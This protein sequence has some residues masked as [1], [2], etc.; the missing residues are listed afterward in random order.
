V[1]DDSPR[2]EG[3]ESSNREQK[4][5]ED[6]QMRRTLSQAVKKEFASVVKQ[7]L[8]QFQPFKSTMLPSGWFMFAH[9]PRPGFSEQIIVVISRDDRFTIELAWSSSSTVPC[10]ASLSSP[11]SYPESNIFADDIQTGECR[12]RIA[13][14]WLPRG[15]WWWELIPS[16]TIAELSERINNPAL[17]LADDTQLVH[18]ALETV[19]TLVND[20]V[21]RVIE[22]GIPYFKERE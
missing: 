14:L 10:R 20:A 2:C 17:L 6:Q 21:N 18:Q 3:T 15:D 4:A 16:P 12:F 9:K 22:L 1:E 19:S 11:R 8:P 7:K 13:K 5:A